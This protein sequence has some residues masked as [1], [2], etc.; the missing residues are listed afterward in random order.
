MRVLAHSLIVLLLLLFLS[1]PAQSAWIADISDFAEIPS[2]EEG[3]D[4]V[5]IWLPCHERATVGVYG[6]KTIRLNTPPEVEHKVLVQY[7]WERRV[8]AEGDSVHVARI[9]YWLPPRRW[10][11]PSQTGGPYAVQ[12]HATVPG[13]YQVE[14]TCRDGQVLTVDLHVTE[15][16]PGPDIGIGYYT[17]PP[18]WEYPLY[19]TYFEHMVELRCNTFTA[20]TSHP[21]PD[22][23]AAKNLAWQLDLAVETGLTDGTVPVFVMHSRPSVLDDA[24]QYGR[25][26]EQWPELVG[27]SRDEP[28]CTDVM[29]NESRSTAAMY[30]EAGY[31]SGSA[32]TAPSIYRMGDGL[33][34]WICIMEDMSDLLRR[35][36]QRQGAELW[37][38]S[39][40]IRGTNAPLNRYFSGWWA[41]A[42][43][44]GAL[45]L[46]VYMDRMLATQASVTVP[47]IVHPDGTWTPC[48]YFEYTLGAPDGPISSVGAEARRDGIVDYMVLQELERAILAARVEQEVQPNLHSLVQEASQW[49]QDNVDKVDTNFW[50]ND[51]IAWGGGEGGDPLHWDSVDLAQPP[52][53]NFNELRAQAIEYTRK[54]Q[55]GPK[56]P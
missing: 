3:P 35:E 44:P 56:A 36:A 37:T 10:R 21:D 39:C 22:A 13:D 25:H 2:G 9:P 45:M 7:I 33:D 55:E 50:P 42:T 26:V 17:V 53:S 1:T 23:P 4:S 51:Y 40:R 18:F 20:Y 16:I 12:L 14:I 49:L 54:L 15:P 46:W 5:T 8:F 38:Y 27:Y 29:E 47:S 41:F 28:G 19:R 24:P 52:L 32:I 31:R 30:R 6:A 34:I 11:P 48:G 43:R